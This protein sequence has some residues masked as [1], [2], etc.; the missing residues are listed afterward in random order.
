ME[1]CA[2]T[3][4]QQGTHHADKFH[5]HLPVLLSALP[6]QVTSPHLGDTR[7][8]HSRHCISERVEL[9]G[10]VPGRNNSHCLKK[11]WLGEV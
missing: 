2:P 1:G 5:L 3:C 9:S 10:S 4:G 11:V 7:P 6:L 8:R